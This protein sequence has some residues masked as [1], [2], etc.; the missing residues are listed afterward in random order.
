VRL[1]AAAAV[2]VRLGGVEVGPTVVLA[3]LEQRAATAD[4]AAVTTLSRLRLG[5]GVALPLWKNS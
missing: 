5:L 3:P 2:L 1:E 4:L